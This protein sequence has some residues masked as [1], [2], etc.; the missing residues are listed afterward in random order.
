[1][2]TNRLRNIFAL[3]IPL[4]IAHGLEEL[5]TGFYNVDSQV[6][7]WFGNL[8]SLPTS[9]ATFILFQVM[10]WLMLVISYLLLLGPKWQLRLM[11]IPGIV[12]IYELHH[13]YKA[14]SLG[15][16]YPGLITAVAL[17]ITGFFFWKELIKLNY[18]QNFDRRR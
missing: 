4:F 8:N 5:L 17:Y 7:L 18:G 2:I 13:L 15:V 1:M 9:Q 3:S 16:Y 10:I 14:I 6:E 12:F 11:F